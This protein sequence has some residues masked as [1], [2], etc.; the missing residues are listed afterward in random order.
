MARKKDA[1]ERLI[2]AA[3]S[4]AA[5]TGW[6]SL[7]MAEVADQAGV[8]LAD[9]YAL[10]PSKMALL[11]GLIEQLDIMVLKEASPD[12]A[13]P[14]RDRLF[15]VLMRRFDLMVP[16]RQAVAAILR[17]LPGDPLCALVAVPR[18]AISV[19]WMLEAAGVPANGLIGAVRIKGL[20]LIYC[21]TLKTWLQD[22]SPDMAR[23]MATLDRG[24]RRAENLMRV[25]PLGGFEGRRA[26]AG[27][28]PGGGADTGEEAPQG[29]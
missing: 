9:T 7:S 25:V 10:Y 28:G 21:C 5:S 3:L 26:R 13:E 23:T 8:S 20:A 27:G 1:S 11:E 17:D 15:E 29:A 24:L 14:V 18:T 12:P 22:D 2:E 4:L 6:R 19:A 16:H